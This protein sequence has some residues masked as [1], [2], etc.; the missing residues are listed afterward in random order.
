MATVVPHGI[1]F[2]GGEEG[3]IRQGMLE[4][5]LFNI[6]IQLVVFY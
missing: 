1:L 2:R 6:S 5:D 4:D 3:K